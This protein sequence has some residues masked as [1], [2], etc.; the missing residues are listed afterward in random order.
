MDDCSIDNYFFSRSQKLVNTL[1]NKFYCVSASRVLN[2]R[3]E[4]TVLIFGYPLV[5]QHLDLVW[6]KKVVNYIDKSGKFCVKN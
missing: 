2:M 4:R 6:I 3:K 1:K 5:I